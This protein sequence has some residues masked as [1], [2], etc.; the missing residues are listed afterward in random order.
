MEN[1]LPKLVFVSYGDILYENGYKTRLLGELSLAAHLDRFDKYLISFE[2]PDSWR[3][4][5]ANLTNLKHQL[6]KLNTKLIIVPRQNRWQWD[7]YRDENKFN[8]ILREI[9]FDRGI[10]HGQSIYGTYL[11]V[12][13]RRRLTKKKQSRIKIIFDMHGLIGP[14]WAVM[15]KNPVK[16]WVNE[17]LEKQCRRQADHIFTASASLADLLKNHNGQDNVTPLPCLTNE[18]EFPQL[19]DETIAFLKKKHHLPDKIIT[20]YAGGMQG[21]QDF[22]LI[23]KL[24]GQHD[25]FLL[26]LT[27]DIEGAKERLADLGDSCRILSVAHRD[28]HQ[29][30]QLADWGWLI[31][32]PDLLNQIAF[33]TKAAEYL[34]S[35]LPIVHNGTID[36]IA[37]IV[38]R[39]R[40]GWNLAKN[41]DLGEWIIYFQQERNLIRQNCRRYARQHL[42]WESRR[43]ILSDTYDHLSRQKIFYL[44]TR[45]F[46]G[47]AQQYVYDL[48]RHF[49]RHHDVTVLVGAGPD[50]L[51]TRLKKKNIKVIKVDQLVRPVSPGHDLAAIFKL[52]QI[53]RQ[54]KPDIIHISSS[55]AGVVGR[56]AAWLAGVP[57]IF[58]TV[59]GWVFNEKI[60]WVTRTLYRWLEWAGSLISE[61]IFCVCRTDSDLAQHIGIEQEKICLIYN[62]APPIVDEPRF[63]GY[64]QLR[65]WQ[66]KYKIIGNVSNFLPNKNLLFWL[67]VLAAVRPDHPDWRFVLA[68][69]GPLE[70]VIKEKI[71]QLDLQSVIWLTGQIDG[72][73]ELIANLDCLMLVSQKEGL[74]YVLLEAMRAKVPVVATPVGGVPELITPEFGRLA[75][76]D[77]LAATVTALE[78]TIKMKVTTG[79]PEKFSLKY[80]MEKYEK[81][82]I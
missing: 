55:K 43:Q 45:G 26:V 73:A 33:P 39:H 42:T 38:D 44:I 51:T 72:T 77:D 3:N 50:Q 30:L 25:L 9:D 52:W 23:K 68:G 20:I 22:S 58:Y 8:Q 4:N 53:C 82:Y 16:K 1:T 7:F 61:R 69:S 70:K 65:K 80:M 71:N 75:P 24:V 19:A 62:G 28:I 48:A 14:E 13:W 41:P 57:R 60:G 79:L 78:E 56:L 74:P 59:H 34:I 10:L 21:W 76:V 2:K 36:D 31:R 18:T 63:A 5:Q 6:D 12:N 67:E 64:K 27:N 29:Y 46:W 11:S 17:W 35:G 40:L 49:S 66:P 15:S 32:R 54:Q 47:G 81:E 37:G